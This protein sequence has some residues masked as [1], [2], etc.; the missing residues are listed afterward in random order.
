MNVLALLARLHGLLAVLAVASC[1]HPALLLR[2]D[3]RPGRRI[4]WLAYAAAGLVTCA[5][6]AGWWIYG[7]YRATVKPW[8]LANSPVV[9]TTWFELKEASATFAMLA[10][11]T[12]AVLV[13]FAGASPAGRRGARR[14]FLLAAIGG[15]FAAG[16]AVV[17][18]SIRDFAA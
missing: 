2:Q 3:A 18:V 16:V 12:G 4:R 10:T 7:D 6:L 15:G 11:W 8:L 17:V 13:R 1:F 5:V 9:H 14:A